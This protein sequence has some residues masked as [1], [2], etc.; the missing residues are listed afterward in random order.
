MELLLWERNAK[1]AKVQLDRFQTCRKTADGQA[2]P[3][4]HGHGKGSVSAIWKPAAE[5][6]DNLEFCNLLAA[7]GI[8]DV[9]TSHEARVSKPTR[10]LMCGEFL[11]PGVRWPVAGLDAAPSILLEMFLCPVLLLR[12]E[13]DD[14]QEGVT[15]I[16]SCSS[17]YLVPA[18][19]CVPVPG[20]IAIRGRAINQAMW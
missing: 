8:D 15:E 7:T 11:Q 19:G 14:A 6:K 17:T 4:G 13:S 3:A 20:K 10:R 18:T 16:L 5:R 2:D 12:D 1:G 9:V